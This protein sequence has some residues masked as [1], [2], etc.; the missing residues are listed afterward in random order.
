MIVPLADILAVGVGVAVR[1]GV[2]VGDAVGVGLGIS[3][4]VG[5]GVGVI[6]VLC[7]SRVWEISA[8]CLLSTA[9]W[10]Y[11]KI[12]DTMPT[13]ASASKM[14][15]S[16]G[17]T[18]GLAADAGNVA[19]LGVLSIGSGVLVGVIGIGGIGG[20]DDSSVSVVSVG[21]GVELSNGE[22][23]LSGV[24]SKFRSSSLWSVVGLAEKEGGLGKDLLS[25]FAM[26]F[27][28]WQIRVFVSRKI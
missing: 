3:I 20:V 25:S 9:D 17:E 11:K 10:E 16:R 24:A 12:E 14:R 18:A 7:C 8:S 22:G 1:T 6:V 26:V 13:P 5:V 4:M 2:A 23:M 27:S 15:I 21:V 28:V 19:G